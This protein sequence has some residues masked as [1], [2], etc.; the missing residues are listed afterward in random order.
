MTTKTEIC[1]YALGHIGKP[2]VTNI[3][4][5]N[6]TEAKYCRRFWD[7]ARQAVLRD[8]NWN[9]ATKR[10]TLAL[11]T[12]ELDDFAYVYRYP[13]D[14][15]K[16]QSI[17]NPA[18]KQQPPIKFKVMQIDGVTVIA[19]DQAE[20]VLEYTVDETNPA[21]FDSQF[22][23]GLAWRLAVYISGP[24]TRDKTLTQVCTTW[25]VNTINAAKTVDAGEG[26]PED[27]ADA[28]WVQAQ[29]GSPLMTQSVILNQVED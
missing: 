18:G 6:S 23:D 9:F 20:A 8:H 15:L 26:E 22:I 2:T 19:T 16:A 14:C 4:T 12:H 25:Y 5:E 7:M 13:T 27:V 3:D 1:N 10:R 29:I 21:V 17:V 11:L 24:L 28:P